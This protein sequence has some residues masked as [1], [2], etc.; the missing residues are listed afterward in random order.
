[1]IT[2]TKEGKKKQKKN[3]YNPESA[4]HGLWVGGLVKKKEQKKYS[5]NPGPIDQLGVGSDQ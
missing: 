2:P 5:S 4:T 1:L 3:K